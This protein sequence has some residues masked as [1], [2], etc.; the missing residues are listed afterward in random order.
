MAQEPLVIAQQ[1]YV[2]AGGHYMTVNGKRTLT[3]QLYA[4][5]QIHLMIVL[6]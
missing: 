6:K 3:G 2:F 5:L 4:E 1:G